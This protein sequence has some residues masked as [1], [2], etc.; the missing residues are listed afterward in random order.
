MRS[1]GAR[2]LTAL[3]LFD[4]SAHAQAAAS[5]PT[6]RVQV[7]NCPDELASR[8]PAVVKLE[9]DVLMRERGP[10]RAPPENIGVRC[11]DDRARIDVTM[12]AVSRASIVDLRALASEHRARAIALASAELV[13]S[14]SREA[15]SADLPAEHSS[16]RNVER[17]AAPAQVP[18]SSPR[19]ERSDRAEL[20]A[21]EPGPITS[22]ARRLVLVG[23]LAELLGKPA[24]LLW[25]ARLAMHVPLGRFFVPAISVDGEMGHVQA[26]SSEVTAQTLA[27]AAALYVGTT[28]W[29]LRWDIGAGARFGWMHL[30]GKPVSGSGLEGQTLNAMWGGPEMRARVSYFAN[31]ATNASFAQL[32]SPALALELGA[33][34]VTLPIRGLLDERERVYGVVGPWGSICAEIGV[35]L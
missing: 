11:E 14:L 6:L 15:P 28:T 25:G 8:L 27:A 19:P 23:G 9:I 5:E 2:T 22:P 31:A 16:E 12:G 20:A 30:A 7:V 32:R 34:V 18:T 24:A 10:T 26:R 1:L 4:V 21:S 35:G 17:P 3:L 29:K 33:G 13:H